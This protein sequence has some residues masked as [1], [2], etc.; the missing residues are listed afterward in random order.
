MDGR[1]LALL[2]IFIG[3]GVAIWSGRNRSKAPEPGAAST[4]AAAS[5][6]MACVNAA[7]AA[8]RKLADAAMLVGRPPVDPGAWSTAQSDLSGAI[9]AAESACGSPATEAD[10]RAADEVRSALSLM[11]STLST[12]EGAARGEGAGG[13]SVMV[14]N[15]EQID[16]HLNRAR[17]NL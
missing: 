15:Q 7:E 10:R 8:N 3:A 9:S 17:G 5:N 12:L 14:Q 11:R 2:A 4:A 16:A 6:G 1:R 13:G